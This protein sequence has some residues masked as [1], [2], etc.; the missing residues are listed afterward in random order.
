MQKFLKSMFQKRSREEGDDTE[1]CDSEPSPKRGASA[2]TQPDFFAP[3]PSVEDG[4]LKLIVSQAPGLPSPDKWLREVSCF[5]TFRG[6]MYRLFMRELTFP[7]K[8][9]FCKKNTTSFKDCIIGQPAQN[10]Q[11]DDATRKYYYEMRANKL[12]IL[13]KSLCKEIPA[14]T[15]RT[16]DEVFMFPSDTDLEVPKDVERLSKFGH[17]SIPNIRPLLRADAFR[18]YFRPEDFKPLFYDKIDIPSNNPGELYFWKECENDALVRMRMYDNA[19]NHE[20]DTMRRANMVD[21]LSDLYTKVFLKKTCSEFCAA[22]E[23]RFTAHERS[24]NACGKCR[25]VRANLKKRFIGHKKGTGEKAEYSGFGAIVV[26][27][28]QQLFLNRKHPFKKCPKDFAGTRYVD[29]YC[30]VEF[31]GDVKQKKTQKK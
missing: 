15:A 30:R 22:N 16:G 19:M 9:F 26:G 31:V 27:K 13:N 1:E 28:I 20:E 2:E 3:R 7:G 17:H 14:S 11:L 23:K 6:K 12:V 5:V 10:S 29:E 21:A 4:D 8:C 25:H 18:E 24:K